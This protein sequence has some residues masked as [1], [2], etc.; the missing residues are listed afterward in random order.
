VA[1][2]GKFFPFPEVAFEP[3]PIQQPIPILVGG[4][5]APALR[6]AGQ[7][8]DGW[9]GMSQT[10]ESVIPLIEILRAHREDA[11]RL[12]RPFDVTV[13]G[14]CETEDDAARWEAAGVHRLIVTPWQRSR[15]ALAAMETF[16]G[17]FLKEGPAL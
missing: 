11:G 1:N 10:P 4:E 5:S 16:A 15:D 14:A 6:R 9:I 13:A 12:D 8:G 3:K 2:D 17:R 7:R